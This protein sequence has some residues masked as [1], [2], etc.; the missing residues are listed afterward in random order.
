MVRLLAGSCRFPTRPL[1]GYRPSL[2]GTSRGAAWSE[3]VT[4]L[5]AKSL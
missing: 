3:E 4:A 1:G 2:G 5:E